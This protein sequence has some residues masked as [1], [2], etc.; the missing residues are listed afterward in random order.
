MHVTL[1]VVVQCLYITD[2]CKEKIQNIQPIYKTI[3]MYKHADVCIETDATFLIGFFS[4]E[5]PMIASCLSSRMALPMSPSGHHAAAVAAQAAAAQAA[6]AQAAAA[7][8]AAALEQLR[9]KLE[10]GEPPKKKMMMVAEEQH[11]IMQH[12]L[13]QNLLAM[14]TQLPLNI[15]L[16]NRGE[17]LTGGLSTLTCVEFVCS[18]CVL[19]GFIIC[20]NLVVSGALARI[21]CLLI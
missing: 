11:R 9:E 16:N 6:A 21:L 17:T 13:Q 8:Q 2:D 4:P 19:W 20:N 18:L 3:D 7:V 14:A 12:A 5:E 1:F 10:S 15:K